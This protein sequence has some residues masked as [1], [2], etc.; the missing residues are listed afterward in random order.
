MTRANK[1]TIDK[2]AVSSGKDEQAKGIDS[3]M[4]AIVA[5]SA[6][7]LI[8]TALALFTGVPMVA[9]I[10]AAVVVVIPSY[11][12][13]SYILPSRVSSEVKNSLSLNSI[14]EKGI[15]GTIKSIIP[16]LKQSKVAVP[17]ALDLV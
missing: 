12:I 9:A 2:D 13:I 10:V 8:G 7:A 4:T 16:V 14:K 3:F 11:I 15:I 6:V 17:L 1:S 5:S